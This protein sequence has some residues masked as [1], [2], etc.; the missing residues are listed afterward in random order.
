MGEGTRK[1]AM[2]KW[3]YSQYSKIRGK[4][5]KTR[6]VTKTLARCLRERTVGAELDLYVL[7]R[8]TILGLCRIDRREGPEGCFLQ[9]RARHER[10]D[11]RE[12]RKGE[13][14]VL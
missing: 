1:S 8:G 9:R 14:S 4:L 7:F 13:V 2:T 12:D 11:G 6:S 5:N 3:E 10:R